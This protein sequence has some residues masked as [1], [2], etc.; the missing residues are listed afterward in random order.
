MLTILSTVL[1]KLPISPAAAHELYLT[2]VRSPSIITETQKLVFKLL[3]LNTLARGYPKFAYA[4]AV[5]HAVTQAFTHTV[6][7][8]ITQAVTH[9]VT[10]AITQVT[11]Q[12]ITNAVSPL[13]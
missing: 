1:L 3:H 8:A 12:D 5:P 4:R 10:Q 13:F 7:Q 11:T 2:R 9:A 6:L